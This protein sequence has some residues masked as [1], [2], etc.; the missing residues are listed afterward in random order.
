MENDEH[1]QLLVVAPV[2]HIKTGQRSKRVE[3]LE[4]DHS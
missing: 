1:I 3:G 2:Q 4:N